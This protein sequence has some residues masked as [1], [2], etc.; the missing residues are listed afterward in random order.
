MA[1]ICL[2]GDLKQ[3]GNRFHMNVDTAAE[4]LNG[5]YSQINGLRKR[6]M[7]G[8]FHV[9]INGVNLTHDTL[10]IGL[11]SRL[12]KKA[13]IHIVPHVVGAK[14]GG[15]FGFIAGTA[16]VV[17]GI[18]VGISTGV[19]FAM[20]AAGAGLGIGGFSQML[21]RLPKTEKT[22]SDSNKNTYFSNLDNTMAQ[23]TAVP[24]IFGRVKTGSKTISRG[25]ETKDEVKENIGD[26]PILRPIKERS[27]G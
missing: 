7:E 19:G 27:N 8:W 11:H 12:P 22:S 10:Q 5:L 23:G 17:A 14:T 21:T 4:G 25:L 1:K 24:V 20:V 9:R 2:Y 3:Y 6:I 16:L 13:V 26:K 18:A 15:L